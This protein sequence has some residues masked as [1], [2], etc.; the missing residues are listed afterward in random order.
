MTQDP[1]PQ[2]RPTYDKIPLALRPYFTFAATRPGSWFTRSAI[3]PVDDWLMRISRGR[4][5]IVGSSALRVLVL[6]TVGRKS[7]EQ[8]KSALTYI[9]DDDRLLLLGS[10]F[11]QIH[12][13]AWSLNLLAHPDASVTIGGTEIPVRATMLTGEE[14][15]RAFGHFLTLKLY[16]QYDARAGRELR[17]FAL[18]KRSADS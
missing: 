8:R 1:F 4:L 16:R 9:R 13:P 7:G 15:E 14:R 5:S 11:G 10:N 12:H 6:S 17:L 18:T 2:A 3:T